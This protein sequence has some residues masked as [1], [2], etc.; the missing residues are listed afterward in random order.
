MAKD[1][2]TMTDAPKKLAPVEFRMEAV[3]LPADA[4]AA[5]GDNLKEMQR[6]DETLKALL[7]KNGMLTPKEREQEGKVFERQHQLS[8]QSAQRFAEQ[9]GKDSRALYSQVRSTNQTLTDHP[10]DEV[11]ASKF[12]TQFKREIL[13]ED[14]KADVL[15]N[16]ERANS[17]A[18]S[19]INTNDK[20]REEA[21][22]S[23]E[24][25][26]S[27]KFKYEDAPVPT[28]PTHV[29]KEQTDGR[30]QKR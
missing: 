1:K 26:A 30:E 8:Q 17:L 10:I 14:A 23:E 24:A 4:D 25:V 20:R 19:L 9:E 21:R 11:V 27:G 6:N 3:S 12:D 2:T 7:A 29:R 22:K 18:E 5:S 15:R 13:S 28:T 16:N